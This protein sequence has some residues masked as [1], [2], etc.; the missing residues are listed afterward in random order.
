V[1]DEGLG[2]RVWRRTRV[3]RFRREELSLWEG[4][5]YEGLRK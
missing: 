3:R 2:T 1:Y 5:F 4:V